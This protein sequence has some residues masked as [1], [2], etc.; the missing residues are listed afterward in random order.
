M[1]LRQH[2]KLT[3]NSVLVKIQDILGVNLTGIDD[4]LWAEGLQNSAAGKGFARQ[5]IGEA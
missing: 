1:P 5:L 2:M 3:A 4:Y